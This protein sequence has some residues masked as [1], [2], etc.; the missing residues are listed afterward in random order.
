VQV[1]FN[2]RPGYVY[3]VSPEQVNVL[4]PAAAVE[5][6]QNVQVI[7]NN[8][9]S[10]RLMVNMRQSAPAPFTW[11]ADKG[12]N[13]L[14]ATHLDYSL[15]GSATLYP[16]VATPAKP[17]ETVLFYLNGMG[18]TNPQIPD[19][20]TPSGLLRVSPIVEV[21]IAGTKIG[22]LDVY[23]VAAGLY[24]VAVKLPTTL[25]DGDLPVYIS[26]NP[27]GVSDGRATLTVAR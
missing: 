14:V 1:L 20:V 24:Q 15:V 21:E 25:Q 8:A 23:L 18:P 26:V 2:G 3:Y 7:S 9:I 10:N 4:V 13:Y 12:R 6:T 17:G 5:A 22:G 19:G 11:G 16:G 27:G